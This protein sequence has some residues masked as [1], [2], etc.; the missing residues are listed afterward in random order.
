MT[1][2]NYNL[3]DE[4][5]NHE[6]ENFLLHP[7]FLSSSNPSKILP[8]KF[9][10][11]SN[12]LSLLSLYNNPSL[13]MRSF[14]EQQL[15]NKDIISFND[16]AMLNKN[17]LKAVFNVLSMLCHCYRWNYLP[18]EDETYALKILN[19]PDKLW[20]PFCLIADILKQPYCGTLYSTT[21]SNFYIVNYK[22][23]EKYNFKD[24][25]FDSINILYNWLPQENAEQLQQW[26]K[27][28]VMTEMQGGYANTACISILCSILNQDKAKLKLG[29]KELNSGIHKITDIFSKQVRSSLLDVSLWRKI[30]QPFFIW[31][32]KSDKNYNFPLEGAS[33]LQV[34][35]IQLIDTIL[36]LEMNSFMGK[37]LIKSRMY[38]PYEMRMF[39][40]KIEQLRYELIKYVQ[41]NSQD[42]ELKELYN[43]CINSM[44]AYRKSH[45]Q[46]GKL[47]IKGDGSEKKITTTG[48][49][50]QSS[51]NANKEFEKDMQ[52]RINENEN[53]ILT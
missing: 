5:I 9:Q 18:P 4:F 21:T 35:C 46:R 29:L 10:V 23:N 12:I 2:I 37:S 15:Q 34:G 39:F 6:A 45:M 28:F 43:S 41:N 3:I 36:G 32:L 24:I 13:G 51:L 38:F 49:S 30:V 26:V 11:Y 47:Y 31:G 50:V 22:E 27:I 53:N 25:N 33:G 8:D 40:I 52:E 48:L 42:N 19:F 1:V 7:V 20:Q 16:I 17:Q 44:L 14:I